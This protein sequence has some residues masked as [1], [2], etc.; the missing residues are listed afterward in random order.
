M[1]FF[2]LKYF[3]FG[4]ITTNR[5]A[6]YCIWVTIN[7][8][9]FIQLVWRSIF[10]IYLIL[11]FFLLLLF[12]LYELIHILFTFF[13]S[14]WLQNNKQNPRLEYTTNI[15]K[16]LKMNYYFSFIWFLFLFLCSNLIVNLLPYTNLNSNQKNWLLLRLSAAHKY[17][18]LFYLVSF[19]ISLTL[20][21][22]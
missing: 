5:S 12:D 17:C 3:S 10:F 2:F 13:L 21:Q 18:G 22:C 16:K 6:R 14:I 4:F 15:D 1:I 19:L 9:T 8:V 7:L 20:C 11:I